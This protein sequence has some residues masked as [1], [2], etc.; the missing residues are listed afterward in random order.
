[1]CH[2]GP[3][4]LQKKLRMAQRSDQ[5]LQMNIV[6]ELIPTG[7]IQCLYSGVRGQVWVKLEL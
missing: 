2:G 4:F 7:L 1:M 5:Q 6:N 3:D